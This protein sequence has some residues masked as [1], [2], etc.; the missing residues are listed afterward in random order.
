MLQRIQ[1]VYLAIASLALITVYFFPLAS[2]LSDISY[3]QF[4][5]THIVSLTPGAEIPVKNSTI[6]PLGVFNGII[7]AILLLTIFLYKRR[8]YQS[9]M[10]K[11]CILMTI[12]LVALVFFVYSPLL[13]RALATEAD[14][15]DNFGLYLILISLV[16]QILAN[17][18]I[19][20]DERLVRSADR[21]R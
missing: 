4:F 5:I 14:Y 13:T 6:M 18:G 20:K 16:M 19:M 15:T 3:A 11:L 17:R 9:R 10:V 2:F 21:L 12:I 7:A 8:L 1:S